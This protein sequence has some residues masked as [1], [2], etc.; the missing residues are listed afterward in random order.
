MAA[1]AGG[2]RSRKFAVRMACG[3]IKLRMPSCEKKTGVSIMVKLG[4]KPRIHARM[5]RPAGGGK[6]Y[7][8]MVRRLCGRIVLKMARDT[9]GTQPFVLTDCCAF[10]ARFAIRGRMRA[11]ERKAVCMV[12]HSRQWNAPPANGM[13]LLAVASHLPAMKVGMTIGALLP[14]VGEYELG[15][16]FPAIHSFM[17]ATKRIQ[18]LGM[19]EIG[20]GP[21][22]PITCGGMAFPARNV[23][24]SM[25]AAGPAVLSYRTAGCD[26]AG[27][28]QRVAPNACVVCQTIPQ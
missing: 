12:F 8:L 25:R 11:D 20:E 1:D 15:V 4:A 28:V 27:I 16:A 10:M 18:G 22:R 7:G 9:V 3:A 19:I 14:Y 13:T 2:W 21:D 24:R 23:E 5:T 17:H 26:S 6:R